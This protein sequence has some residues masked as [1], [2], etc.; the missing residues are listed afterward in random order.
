MRVSPEFIT[1]F[2]TP[3]TAPGETMFDGFTGVRTADLAAR[4]CEMLTDRV[5]ANAAKIVLV[6]KWALATHCFVSRVQCLPLLPNISQI[7]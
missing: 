7:H 3:H 4:L 1:R 5:K 2:I 6:V